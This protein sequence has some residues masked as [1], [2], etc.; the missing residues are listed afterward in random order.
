MI[1]QDRIYFESELG[2]LRLKRYYKSDY[3]GMYIREP[4]PDDYTTQV[5]TLDCRTV[6]DGIQ[7]VIDLFQWSSILLRVVS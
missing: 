3:E 6:K 5:I 1:S 2:N 4:W 7:E